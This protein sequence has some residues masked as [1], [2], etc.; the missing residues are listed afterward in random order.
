MLGR[1]PIIRLFDPTQPVIDQLRG[2]TAIRALLKEKVIGDL[3]D[4]YEPS[5]DTILVPS[6][7]ILF[8]DLSII[9]APQNKQLIE[10]HSVLGKLPMILDVHFP[11]W[12]AERISI[13]QYDGNEEHIDYNRTEGAQRFFSDIDNVTDAK[14]LVY[15]ADV[16][17][18][19]HVS[20]ARYLKLF[21]KNVVW[22]PDVHNANDA[23]IFCRKFVPL[24]GKAFI[25]RVDL[26]VWNRIKLWFGHHTFNMYYLLIRESALQ[27]EVEKLSWRQYD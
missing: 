27:K 17:T 26:P 7:G 1:A 10:R 22:L 13:L 16:V 20:W 2:G 11:F 14:R 9:I 18:T 8:C 4:L 23:V 19:P 25:N 6:T 15:E 3:F 5:G 21:N 12:D 24:L